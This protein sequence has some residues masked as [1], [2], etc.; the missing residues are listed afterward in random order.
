MLHLMCCVNM[1][2]IWRLD[3]WLCGLEFLTFIWIEYNFLGWGLWFRPFFKQPQ[4]L[5]SPLSPFEQWKFCS[6]WK[7]V[8]GNSREKWK[9]KHQKKEFFWLPTQHSPFFPQPSY[10][11]FF[12]YLMKNL[13]H[14]G[15]KGLDK[16]HLVAIRSWALNNLLYYILNPCP[17]LR[18][19]SSV[20]TE[21]KEEVS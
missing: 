6:F 13:N 16:R 4:Q 10:L 18:I 11:A 8:C 3:P 12:P 7:N 1:K 15:K 17:T 14:F 19:I 21:G 9:K 20:N 2:A 5:S